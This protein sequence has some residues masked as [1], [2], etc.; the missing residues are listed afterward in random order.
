MR[1]KGL[2]FFSAVLLCLCSFSL[3]WGQVAAQVIQ[4]AVKA[5][6]EA[7]ASL[8]AIIQRVEKAA[9]TADASNQRSLY[10][11]LGSLQEQ[12]GE[13]STAASWYAKAAEISAAPAP[14]TLAL[15]DEELILAAARCSLS[16]GESQQAEGYLTFLGNPSNEKTVAYSRLYKLWS[17][18]CRVQSSMELVEPV[19][20]LQSYATMDSMKWVRPSVYLTLW[21][22][23]EEAEWSSKLQKEYPK[24]AEAAVVTGKGQMLPTP[25]WFFIPKGG[26]VQ[27]TAEK[28]SLS[29][30]SAEAEKKSGTTGSSGTTESHVIIKQQVGFFRNRENAENL[31]V[32]LKEAG[33]QGDISQEQRPS[34]TI[35]FVVTVPEDKD[36]STALKLKTAGFECSPVF[37]DE[38]QP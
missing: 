18:L 34:G 35:Y 19:A 25:F 7:N 31:V 5:S 4:D 26:A 16:C 8:S 15:T 30:G 24:S 29:S 37:A 33:F 23:T 38:S 12:L 14:N 28:S 22:L 6:A 11:F 1:L 27:N 17:R 21:H 36:N 2:K 9:S 13:Y 32:R 3:M 10:T 20:L